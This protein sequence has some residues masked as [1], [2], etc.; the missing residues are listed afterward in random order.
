[1]TSCDVTIVDLIVEFMS[2]SMSGLF[3]DKI[4][5]LIRNSVSSFQIS[6]LK[7]HRK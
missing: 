1:M 4:T 2:S 5:E 7:P 6:R 3:D